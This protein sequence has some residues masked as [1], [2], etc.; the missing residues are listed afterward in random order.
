MDTPVVTGNPNKDNATPSGGI[1]AIDA[2]MTEYVLEGEG[3]DAPVDYWMPFNEDVGIHVMKERAHFGSTIY[4]TNG[5]HGCVNT[6]YDMV[7][8]I[9]NTV[10][11]GTPVI[12]YE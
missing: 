5:S 10:S 9:Y 12:V 7:E 1:W 3:Y 4:L 11:I 8:I 2:K 6:P